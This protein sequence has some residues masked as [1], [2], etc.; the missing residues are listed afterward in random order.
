MRNKRGINHL[1]KLEI[2]DLSPCLATNLLEIDTL[3]FSSPH[4]LRNLRDQKNS[5]KLRLRIETKFEKFLL[6][7]N[8]FIVSLER[9]SHSFDW[10]FV[11]DIL[12]LLID[13]VLLRPFGL[14]HTFRKILSGA[15]G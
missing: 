5:K 8:N 15:Q 3:E 12:Y 13:C 2:R 6:M 4:F 10:I 14:E 9:Q 7:E 11:V 1:D